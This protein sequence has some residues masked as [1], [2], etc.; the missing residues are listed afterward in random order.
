MKVNL[1]HVTSPV[2]HQHLRITLYILTLMVLHRSAFI[3]C[4]SCI[5]THLAMLAEECLQ[6]GSTSRCWQAAHPQVSTSRAAACWF[7]LFWTQTMHN[8]CYR[9][10]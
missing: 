4:F 10:S 8:S 9:K 7:V 3:S 6:V 1:N 2:H 5:M